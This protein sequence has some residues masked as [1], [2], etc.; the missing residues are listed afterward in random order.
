MH[1]V[2]LSLFLFSRRLDLI[3][4]RAADDI[5]HALIGIAMINYPVN[6]LT[7]RRLQ[8]G[9]WIVCSRLIFE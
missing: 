2:E 3:C 7:S 4:H 1:V 9:H 8:G 5:D 6:A